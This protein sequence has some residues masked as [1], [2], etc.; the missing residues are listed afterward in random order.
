MSGRSE[1][2]EQE[3]PEVGH[4]VARNPSVRAVK[5]NSHN[6]PSPRL[7]CQAGASERWQ[8][9]LRCVFRTKRLGF[10]WWISGAA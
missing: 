5:Q 6:T 1:C 8:R 4:K 3:H 9:H 2:L 7:A 10:P